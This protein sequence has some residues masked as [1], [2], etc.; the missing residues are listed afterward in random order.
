MPIN[1]ENLGKLLDRYWPVL[2]EWAGGASDGTE[3]IVQAAFIKLA[4]EKSISDVWRSQLTRNRQSDERA[5]ET[6]RA[7]STK[8]TNTESEGLDIGTETVGP[9]VQGKI[10]RPGDFPLFL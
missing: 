5:I 1:P 4:A 9:G 10:L 8:L 3:D 7:S 6:L 2:V